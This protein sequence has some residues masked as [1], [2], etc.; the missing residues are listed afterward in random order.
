M[1]RLVNALH[2]P[3]PRPRHPAGAARDTNVQPNPDPTGP[4]RRSEAHAEASLRY[5]LSVS[6]TSDTTSFEAPRCGSQVAVP[7]LP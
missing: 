5:T 7:P 6:A 1:D 4:R 2:P 3:S